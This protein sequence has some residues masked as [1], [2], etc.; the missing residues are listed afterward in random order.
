MI[1]CTAL[2][3]QFALRRRLGRPVAPVNALCDVD[4]T[5]E[6]GTIHGLIGPNGSGKSTLL[7][8]LSTLLLP[9]S[10]GA[11]V[12]GFDV[13]AAALEVRAAIGLSTGDDRSL[14]WR[15][16]G[17]QN[18]EFYAGLYRL[19]SPAERIET[20]LGQFNLAEAADRPVGGYSQG[21]LHRLGLA[22]AVLHRPRVLLLDE[23]TRSLDPLAREDFHAVLRQ[24]QR[25]DR[26]TILMATHDLDEAAALCDRVSVLSHGR[27]TK[28][29][30]PSSPGVLI[31]AL[32][33]A[34]A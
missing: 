9:S 2:N 8:I 18:L 29:V 24:M 30:A 26:I 15:L 13:T 28:D 22:R 11:T 12:A 20:L 3:K 32:R 34:T 19:R 33:E 25:S 7:R 16:T 31:S 10:G 1:S 17:R 4:L 27:I 5:V 23:P 6:T 14:Y 21:M